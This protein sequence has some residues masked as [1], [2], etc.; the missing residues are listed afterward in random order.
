MDTLGRTSKNHAKLHTVYAS[1][2]KLGI[3][4]VILGIKTNLGPYP[5]V[6]HSPNQGVISS[7]PSLIQ[8]KLKETYR[9]QTQA[10]LRDN[11]FQH[12]NPGPDI[13]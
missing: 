2:D 3:L 11:L 1:M 10:R 8:P 13:G 7:P 6:Y 12:Y 5:R 4:T 9:V